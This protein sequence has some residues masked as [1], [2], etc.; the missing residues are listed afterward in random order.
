MFH[1]I[2]FNFFWLVQQV[3]KI[4]SHIKADFF[5]EHL[6]GYLWLLPRANTHIPY[7]TFFYPFFLSIFFP[8]YITNAIFYIIRYNSIIYNN[9]LFI[10]K[11]KKRKK[12]MQ[13]Y[14][15][16]FCLNLKETIFILRLY[17]NTKNFVAEKKLY[18]RNILDTVIIL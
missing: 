13:Y 9:E 15:F 1:F 2:W 16:F 5:K 14:T 4:T 10:G 3:Q 12:T 8:F 18:I 17:I 6:M 11:Q 7:Q